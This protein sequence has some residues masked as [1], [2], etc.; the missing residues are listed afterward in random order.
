VVPADRALEE[1]AAIARRLAESV[2]HDEL[3]QRVVDLATGYLPGCE[4][5]SLMI[6]G[7]GSR[8]STPAFSSPTAAAVD[9]AQYEVDEGPCLES[10]RSQ[11]TVIVDDL[12]HDDRWPR[13]RARA[14]DEGVRSMMT[15]RLFVLGD[16]MGAL[17]LYSSYPHA[18]RQRSIV[19]GSVFASHAAVALKAAIAE[20]GADAAL[21]S[22]DLIGQAKG[23]IMATEGRT[24]EAAFERLR[25]ASQARN[26]AVRDLADEVV[27]T[28][29]LAWATTVD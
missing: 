5:A 16:T 26:V 17:N 1:V 18:F 28:G 22:R 14:L 12:A 29:E 27:R 21:R 6:V 9:R 3:L 13:F 23:I 4:G 8:I 11:H 10:I 15:V 2:D 20:V 24:A 7:H 19:L 25:A